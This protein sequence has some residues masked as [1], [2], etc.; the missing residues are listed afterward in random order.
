MSGLAWIDENGRK[1][2]LRDLFFFITFFSLLDFIVSYLS[3]AIYIYSVDTPYP[4]THLQLTAT[5][6]I[7][8]LAMINANTA[9][10]ACSDGAVRVIEI[11]DD[12]KLHIPFQSQNH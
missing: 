2:Y 1:R 4:K 8:D 6:A 11:T 10:V 7:F 3:G 9:V 5:V 12:C